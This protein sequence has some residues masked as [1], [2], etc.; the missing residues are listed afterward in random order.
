[1]SQIINLNRA[2]KARARVAAKAVAVANRVT[3][4]LGKSARIVGKA[5][6]VDAAR[7]LEEHKREP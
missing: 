4:G 3:F 2:R 5:A 7:R 1:M 6:N